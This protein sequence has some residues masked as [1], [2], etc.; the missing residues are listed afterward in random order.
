MPGV[1][2][3]RGNAAIVDYFDASPQ[4]K[5]GVQLRLKSETILSGKRRHRARSALLARAEATF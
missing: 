5:R 2:D 3:R 1:P 4:P